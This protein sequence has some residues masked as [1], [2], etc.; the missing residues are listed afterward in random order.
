MEWESGRSQAAELVC[1][2]THGYYLT[3]WPDH[4][5]V[6]KKQAC[7]RVHSKWTTLQTSTTTAKQLIMI[8]YTY[9]VWLHICCTHVYTCFYPRPRCTIFI[10]LTQGYPWV[11]SLQQPPLHNRHHQTHVILCPTIYTHPHPH[12]DLISCCCISGKWVVIMCTHKQ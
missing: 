1:V 2:Y 8:M 3:L 11:Y 10:R 7:P 5:L 9:Y 12:C 4:F 6:V